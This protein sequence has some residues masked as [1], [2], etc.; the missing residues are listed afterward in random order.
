VT[1]I[2]PCPVL[3]P[4]VL[5]GVGGGRGDGAGALG[6][7]GG[8]C[9]STRGG[10]G[11]GRGEGIVGGRGEGIVGGRG[12]GGVGGFIGPLY[13]TL[14]AAAPRLVQG[15]VTDGNWLLMGKPAA[16]SSEPLPALY[17]NPLKPA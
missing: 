11:G 2:V 4:P 1:I 7:C 6:G 3:N 8:G 10:V 16:S 15:G 9:A 14:H 13:T 12:E 5:L 17:R